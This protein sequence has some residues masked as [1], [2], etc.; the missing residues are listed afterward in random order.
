ME[1]ITNEK[2][3]QIKKDMCF[4]IYMAGVNMTGEYQGCWVR[5]RDVENIVERYLKDYTQ[6]NSG[7]F[8]RV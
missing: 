7:R 5:F 6:D 4:D 2:L 1:K 8:T 3:S